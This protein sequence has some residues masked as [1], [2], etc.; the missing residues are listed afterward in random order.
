M[1]SAFAQVVFGS[2]LHVS[3]LIQRQ[4]RQGC[5][6]LGSLW[7]LLFDPLTRFLSSTLGPS[8]R[9][10]VGYADYLAFALRNI[11]DDLGPQ[12]GLYPA[13]EVQW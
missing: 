9:V 6:A 2:G 5:L 4:I 8:L 3:I 10:L 1:F 13:L 12:K 7:A 11:L